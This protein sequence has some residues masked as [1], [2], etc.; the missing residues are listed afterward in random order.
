MTSSRKDAQ[1]TDRHAVILREVATSGYVTIEA[2]A[3]RFGVSAQTVRRDII[4]LSNT[5]QLQRFHG[6]AGPAGSA[7]AAR[8][9]YGAKSEIGRPEKAVVGRR[10]AAMVPDRAA[11]YLDVGTTV[12]AC[13][14][15]LARRKGFIVFTNSMRAAMLFSPREHEVHVLGGRM[16]G[17]DGSL[18]GEGVIDMLRNV[19]LD[20]ALIACSA[21]DDDGRVMDFD[22]SKI[23][24][25]RAAMEAARSSFLL[26][27]RSKFGR[28]AL[29]TICEAERF[30]AVV[31]EDDA[32]LSRP[33]AHE[34]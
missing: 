34:G 33:P 27:T 22:L 17:R 30:D 23:A 1:V 15:E 12:E 7:E 13:A 16:A 3:A 21:V 32:A 26:A 6:G 11:V 4:A 19:R 2:L 9:D 20:V 31:T 25:K 18:V 5:G 8:L 10:A 14:R 29:G 28:S 24:V